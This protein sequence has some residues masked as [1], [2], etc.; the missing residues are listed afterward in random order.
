MNRKLQTALILTLAAGAVLAQATGEKHALLIGIDGYKYPS[1]SIQTLRYAIADVNALEDALKRNGY[2][3][4]RLTE[5]D[6]EREDV[7]AA[8]ARYALRLRREDSFLLYYA[9]H[10][11]RNKSINQ[12]TYW[13]P[14]DA[15]LDRLEV[16]GIRLPHLADYVADIPAG[17]KLILLDHCFSGDLIQQLQR[18]G[19]DPARRS[20]RVSVSLDTESRGGFSVDDFRSASDST[21]LLILAAS[22]R[23]AYE[24]PQL[25]HG[26]FTAA[27]LDAFLTRN[28]DTNGDAKLSVDELR[29]YL[30]SEVP[31]LSQ[32]T[33]GTGQQVLER[34][35]GAFSGWIVA[36]S[37]PAAQSEVDQLAERYRGK[38]TAWQLQGLIPGDAKSWYYQKLGAW[39]ASASTGGAVSEAE[40]QFITAMRQV[41]DT[42]GASD[43]VRAEQ[44]VD[45]YRQLGGNQ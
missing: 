39:R 13:L 37:L 25:Q 30:A 17:R 11:V 22:M 12:R 34:A 2:Y 38:L 42:E 19:T 29:A 41:F 40:R 9:G 35:V 6:A 10:G 20:E 23:D 27:L 44:L 18:D 36:E 7:V 26:V 32:R 14:Y 3:V 21:A 16:D 33:V 1:S 28:A 5:G 4:T 15:T 24:S 43:A 31:A 8:L 45:L